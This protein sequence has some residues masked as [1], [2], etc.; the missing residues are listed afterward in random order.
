MVLLDGAEELAQ[1]CEIVLGT[2]QGEW[3]LNPL[4]G[5][6][7]SKLNGKKISPEEAKE[8]IRKG[9]RQESRIKTVDEIRVELDTKSRESLITFKATSAE[10]QVITGGTR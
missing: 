7:F 10:G 4:L 9:L 5:I 2:N 6:D 8:E 1:C 3:F